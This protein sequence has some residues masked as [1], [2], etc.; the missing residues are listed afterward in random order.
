MIS[1]K[2]SR[3]RNLKDP[4]SARRPRGYIDRS[5]KL[6]IDTKFADAEP[7]HEG[8][9]AVCTRSDPNGE[10]GESTWGFIDK[11]GKLVIW[12]QFNE[13]TRFRDGVAKVHVGGK[14]AMV[15][16]APGWWIGGVWYL[17]DRSGKRL[18]KLYKSD[19]D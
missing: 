11:K 9:A 7:F 13:V 14:W 19:Q 12:P 8:L 1:R 10:L 3:P 16:D 5:G 6:V 4:F 18:V 2:E 17:I 15:E